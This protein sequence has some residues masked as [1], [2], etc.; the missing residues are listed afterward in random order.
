MKLSKGLNKFCSSRVT[1]LR[2]RKNLRIL[3]GVTSRSRKLKVFLKSLGRVFFT[4][5]LIRFVFAG[6]IL[7]GLIVLIRYFLFSSRFNLVAIEI[8][9][10][11]I[12][13]GSQIE[14]KINYLLGHN[15]FF[16][17][18]SR[19]GE[20]IGRFSPY[21]KEAKVEKDLPGRI[22][23]TI[24][25]REPHLVWINFIGAYLIDS[26]GFVLELCS[27]FEDLEISEGDLD[28]LKGYGDLKGLEEDS[29]NE[30]S[31]EEGSLSEE[32]G[33]KD[34]GEEENSEEQKQELSYE[35]KHKLIE[36]SRNE[37]VSRVDKFW[38]QNLLTFEEKYNNFPFVFSYERGEY[39]I[40]D[41]LAS[42][43]LDSTKAGLG[44]DFLGE[45]PVRYIWESNYRF[46]IHLSKRR[47]IVFSTRRE[48]G[49]QIEDLRVLLSKLKSEGKN[50]NSIDLS[51]DVIV[52]EIDE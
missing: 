4:N 7:S 47:E 42:D 41:V 24:E 36:E 49:E 21:I 11:K 9:G 31:D 10:N 33:K 17:R 8:K 26:E 3:S 27:D 6:V 50:Y 46:V 32:E 2:K 45:E 5:S 20:E 34:E 13:E 15:I 51:S 40:R 48:F 38:E 1:S 37:I 28:L 35:E 29:S 14:S 23:I 39:S 52:Y 22:T 44:I 16:I 30:S 19:L 25:E 18:G 43:R 12:V